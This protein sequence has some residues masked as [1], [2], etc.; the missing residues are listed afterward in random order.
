MKL[1]LSLILKNMTNNW[2]SLMGTLNLLV[3]MNK[4]TLIPTLMLTATSYFG[5]AASTTSIY[6]IFSLPEALAATKLGD[7][8]KFKK[9]AVDADA[10]VDKGDL[11]AAK[12]RMKDLES[13]W[14]EA[15]AGIKP[16]EKIEA[17][18]Q[19]GHSRLSRL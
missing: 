3:I 12:A 9:I 16:G 14:D 11:A 13:A 10:L 8:S 1:L 7:L 19:S 15:E 4:R 5:L 17:M 6:Q 2:V 18:L